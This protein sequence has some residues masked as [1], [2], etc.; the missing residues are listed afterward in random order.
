[1][2]DRLS[3]LMDAAAARGAYADARFVRQR[4]QYVA[5]RNGEVDDLSNHEDEGIG[6]RVRVGCAPAAQRS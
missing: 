3:E 1:M 5:T 4:S 6:V 2:Q